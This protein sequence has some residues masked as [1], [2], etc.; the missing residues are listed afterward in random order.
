VVYKVCFHANIPG[1]K[2]GK[3]AFSELWLLMEECDHC[4]F[5]DP[6]NRA[7]RNS[8][9]GGHANWLTRQTAL[10][11]EAGFRQDGNHGFFATLGDNREFHLAALDIEHGIRRVPLRKDEFIG[12]VFANGFSSVDVC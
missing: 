1:K 4:T 9:G 10:A 5:F 12:L 3:K 8:A 6:D 11:K 7:P 2:I